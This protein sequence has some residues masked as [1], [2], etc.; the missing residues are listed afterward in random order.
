[1]T[2]SRAGRSAVRAR[3][4]PALG[5]LAALVLSCSPAGASAQPPA[6]PSA[7]RG[8]T[9]GVSAILPV[10]VGELRY[11]EA[12]AVAVPYFPLGGGVTGRIGGELEGGVVLEAVLAVH[13][14]SV[15]HMRANAG[16]LV[17]YRG[18]LQL[19]WMIETGTDVVPF[20]GA[21]GSLLVLSR[22]GSV[23][24]TGTV[25][26]VL[27]AQW[28]L[29]RWVALELAVEGDVVFPGAALSDVGGYVSPMLGA[30]FY[31]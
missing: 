2:S 17:G 16:A 29:A 13:G 8:F 31:F 30:D 5:V 21:G 24:T 25:H 6:S 9:W 14:H 1:M 7:G 22:G 28:M 19:R 4:P 11:A 20:V 3:R 26:A 27:G 10:W 12:P 15:D 23:G 18:G